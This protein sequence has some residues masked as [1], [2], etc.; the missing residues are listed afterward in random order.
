MAQLEQRRRSVAFLPRKVAS[1]NPGLAINPPTETF[2][3]QNAILTGTSRRYFVP[4]FPGPLSLKATLQGTSTWKVDG[5][6]CRVS[7]STYLLV[8]AGQ[9]YTIMYDEPHD[10]TTFVLLFRNG[11]LE[12]ISGGMHLSE[13]PMLDDPFRSER[14]E[15][16]IR[17][18]AGE[19]DVLRK[20]RSFA[21][22]LGRT[23]VA[24]EI[25]DLRFHELGVTLV[26][27]MG[28]SA[29]RASDISASKESTRLELLRRVSI[30]RDFLVSMSDTPVTVEHAARVACISTFHF[31]RVFAQAFGLSPHLCLRNFR[32]QRAA[33]MLQ[34]SDEPIADIVLRVGLQS[35]SSFSEAF[36]RQYGISPILFRRAK[37]NWDLRS[38]AI[39]SY[40][41]RD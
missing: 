30:G 41:R 37:H 18:H 2:G 7:E 25:W 21:N 27:E 9:P 11:Y 8:N 28:S 13:R 24:P 32:M 16:P 17:L 38:P 36:R 19:S 15:V 35:A 29:P 5:R 3:F 39:V 22:E 4:D 31:H 26:K 10:V 12:E 1:L 14:I 20:L 40:P 34:F 6:E 33:H 23:P